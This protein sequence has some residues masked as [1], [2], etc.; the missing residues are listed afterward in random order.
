MSKEPKSSYAISDF[1]QGK[2]S[3]YEVLKLTLARSVVVAIGI[4]I[5]KLV[6]MTNTL[7]IS[8]ITSLVITSW[9]T[10]D[11]YLH[12]HYNSSLFFYSGKPP[13]TSDSKELS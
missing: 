6:R 2:G 11:Y 4:S 1:V 8:V 3:L 13:R 7:Q 9:I 12:F 5:S 10:L